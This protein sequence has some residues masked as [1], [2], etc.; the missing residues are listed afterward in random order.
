MRQ[1]KNLIDTGKTVRIRHLPYMQNGFSIY[2]IN[3]LGRRCYDGKYG[4]EIL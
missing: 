1:K 4:K 3:K 2:G